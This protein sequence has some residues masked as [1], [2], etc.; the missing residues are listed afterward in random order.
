MSAHAI[1]VVLAFDSPISVQPTGMPRAASASM[2][3]CVLRAPVKT[4]HLSFG[5]FASSSALKGVRSRTTTIASASAISFISAS[6]RRRAVC[7]ATS[8]LASTGVQ[9]ALR[10]SESS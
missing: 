2:S 5:S 8:A 7:T 10:R 9:S 4:K 1:S 6:P 3:S